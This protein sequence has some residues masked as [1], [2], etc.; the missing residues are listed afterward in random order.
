M[1]MK[2]SC[3][4]STKIQH[5]QDQTICLNTSC[6]N[7]M[8]SSLSQKSRNWNNIVFFAFFSFFIILSFNDFSSYPGKEINN[9][10][11]VGSENQC[12]PL[13]E[14]NLK[15]VLNENRIICPEQVFAQ[16]MIESGN[17]K[18]YLTKRT[19]NILGMRYPYKRKTS[20]VGIYISS[21]NLIFK[22]NQKV[23]KKYNKLNN[24]AVYDNWEACVKDYKYWQEKSFNLSEV[25]LNFLGNVYAE[26]SAYIDKL[27]SIR[28]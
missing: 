5:L 1:I 10:K 21:K 9:R 28:W 4:Q 19:N 24:Y 15:I 17:L 20:A 23:L 13:T 26:D 18:S 7:Y 3:C 22:G 11:L 16:I 27:K 14:E 6:P 8:C 2:T 12:R 25:Y